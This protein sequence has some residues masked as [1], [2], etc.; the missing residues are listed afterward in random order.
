MPRTIDADPISARDVTAAETSTTPVERL[1][2]G[3]LADER[4]ASLRRRR[5]LSAIIYD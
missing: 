2:S 4:Q 5:K 3:L 1:S